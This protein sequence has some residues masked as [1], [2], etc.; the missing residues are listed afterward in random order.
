[1]T[2]MIKRFICAF[3]SSSVTPTRESMVATRQR[4]SCRIQETSAPLGGRDRQGG[5]GWWVR[6]EDPVRE[7][8]RR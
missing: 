8:I 6:G 1:M 3:P 4:L 5:Q 2:P 7:S